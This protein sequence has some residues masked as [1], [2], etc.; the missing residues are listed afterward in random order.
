MAF[1]KTKPK[2]ALFFEVKSITLH[3]MFNVKPTKE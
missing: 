3:D 1:P 2:S